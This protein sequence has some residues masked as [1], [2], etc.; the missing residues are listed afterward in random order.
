MATVFE[1]QKDAVVMA[2]ISDVFT[3][4]TNVQTARAPQTNSCYIWNASRAEVWG[5][6]FGHLSVVNCQASFYVQ[7]G[8]DVLFSLIPCTLLTYALEEGDITFARSDWEGGHRYKRQL[9]VNCHI[10]VR[11]PLLKSCFASL[12][13]RISDI[14]LHWPSR[15]SFQK[16]L[17][18][19][20]ENGPCRVYVFASDRM[21][22]YLN[23]MRIFNLKSYY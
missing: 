6:P 1:P 7:V 8:S 11:M 23:G 21:I 15:P 4:R 2:R 22:I 10:P 19:I 3:V 17:N 14:C 18:K 9:A 16:E 12:H 13:P 20:A 5:I